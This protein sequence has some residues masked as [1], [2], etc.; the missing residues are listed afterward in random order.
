MIFTCFL[1]LQVELIA[2][3]KSQE[4]HLKVVGKNPSRVASKKLKKGDE[5]ILGAGGRFELISKYSYC[6]FFGKR[7]DQQLQLNDCNTSVGA[8]STEEDG[9]L[10][11]KSVKRMKLDDSSN[12]DMPRC[13]NKSSTTLESFFGV[14][15]SATKQAEPHYHECDTLLIF[16]YGPQCPNDK[17]AAFDLDGTLISTLSG[18]KFANDHSDWKLMPRVKDKLKELHRSGH[19][20]VILTNQGGLSKGKPTK[21]DFKKKMNAIATEL[22]LPLLVMAASDQDVYRKPCTGMWNHIIEKENGEV[23]PNLSHSFYVGDAAGRSAEW[24]PGL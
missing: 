18:K 6:I 1:L 4:V 2:D 11:Q 9:S 7:L 19:R 22:D 24:K 12:K 3:Y 17:I 13:K 21:D 23:L 10:E 5:Y 20:I 14:K 16:R 8:D 15:P